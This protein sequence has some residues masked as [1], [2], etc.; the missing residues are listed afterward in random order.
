MAKYK[1]KKI[2]K[3][4]TIIKRKPVS[5][6]DPAFPYKTITK[7]NAFG[8]KEAAN[9]TMA[10]FPLDDN[11]NPGLEITGVHVLNKKRT[12][13]MTGLDNEGERKNYQFRKFTNKATKYKPRWMEIDFEGKPLKNSKIAIDDLRME[14]GK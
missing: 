12:L 10:E 5:T 3:K 7:R 4:K 9:G 6:D 11:S 1:K 13:S 14:K 8:L 2:V